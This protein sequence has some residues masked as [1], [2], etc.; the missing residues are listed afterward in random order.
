[1][2]HDT[3]PTPPS[4]GGSLPKECEAYLSHYQRCMSKFG[5][6]QA[7]KTVATIR[8]TYTKIPATYLVQTCAA[9]DAQV[10]KSFKGC[11]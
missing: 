1:M 4:N 11:K 5:A 10:S 8:D 7:A 6:A 2:H 3:T 9:A